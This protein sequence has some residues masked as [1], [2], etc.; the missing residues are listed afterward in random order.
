[1]QCTDRVQSWSCPSRSAAAPKAAREFNASRRLPFPGEKF[2]IKQTSNRHTTTTPRRTSPP[3]IASTT[4]PTS[5]G[6]TPTPASFHSFPVQPPAKMFRTAV[7]RS[8][9]LAS[10]TAAV[11]SAAAHSLRLAAPSAAKS[12]VP[13]ASASWALQMRG[14]ASGGGLTKQEVYERIKELLSGFDKVLFVLHFG[15]C[16]WSWRGANSGFFA[17]G[18]QPRERECYGRQQPMVVEMCGGVGGEG[19]GM[20]YGLG[21]WELTGGLDYGN[22][23]LRQ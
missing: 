18:Q 21:E 7:L 2:I 19:G 4:R 23:P 5:T 1:M 6:H 20:M 13:K 22:R 17:A 16:F 14:Y 10:R 15:S 12:F 11:R 9:A 8:V 3:S